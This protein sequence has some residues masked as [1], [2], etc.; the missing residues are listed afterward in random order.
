MSEV[1][2]IEGDKCASVQVC[3]FRCMSRRRCRR[4]CMHKE[5]PHIP[6]YTYIHIYNPTCY[7]PL[8]HMMSVVTTLALSTLTPSA[9]TV[10]EISAPFT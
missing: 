8:S 9:L 6:I 1:C 2:V 7:V 3:R 4:R 10:I 5:P